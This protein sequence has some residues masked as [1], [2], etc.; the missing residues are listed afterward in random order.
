M[1][2]ATKKVND[3][4]TLVRPMPE[5]AGLYLRTRKQDRSPLLQLLSSGTTNLSGL[6]FDPLRMKQDKE[7]RDLVTK[8]YLDAVLD[9]KTQQLGTEYGFGEK[10]AALPWGGNGVQRVEDF[11][12]QNGRRKA[13]AISG[14]V[15]QHGLTA[16]LAPTHL[17]RGSSD[18]WLAADVDTT[19]RLQDE[20]SSSAAKVAIFYSLAL[21]YSLLRD[22]GEREAIIRMLEDA[23]ID[24]LWL[25]IDGLGNNATQA[26]VANYI[27]ACG[28]FHSLRVPILADH[29]GGFPGLALVAMGAVTGLSHGITVGEQFDSSPWVK[30][31]DGDIHSLRTRAYIPRLDVNLDIKLARRLANNSPRL[32]A[33]FACHDRGCCERGLTD[34]LENPGKHFA[35]QRMRQLD[36]LGRIPSSMRA[37]EFVDNDLRQ[38]TEDLIKATSFDLG[39]DKLEKRLVLHRR[40]LDGLRV[41]LSKHLAREVRQTTAIT[42]ATRRAR[43]ATTR[44]T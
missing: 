32:R 6:V 5:P 37:R 29:F 24:Q 27:E 10:L 36:A 39:D 30:P 34:M 38:L 42:L 28:E 3:L 2:Q 16:V 23:P 41:M 18:P 40:R 35:Y 33:M 26:G 12:G 17:I 20:L 15:H 14:F 4:P 8:R 43:E 1:E 9:S 19:K 22:H 11:L 13:A 44:R 7:L 31:R 25:K 21:P